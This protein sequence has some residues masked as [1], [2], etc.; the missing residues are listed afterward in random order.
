MTF[1][2]PIPNEE[3]YSPEEVQRELFD[4]ILKVA[5]RCAYDLAHAADEIGMNSTSELFRERARMW[6]EIFEGDGGKKYRHELHDEIFNRDIVIDQYRKLVEKHGL[7]EEAEK[8][9]E[10]LPF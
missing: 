2:K 4:L 8:F 10:R 7:L 5:R 9:D 3:D 6:I 1:L